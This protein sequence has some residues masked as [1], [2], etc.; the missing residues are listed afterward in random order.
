MAWIDYRRAFDVPRD[1]MGMSI[2]LAGVNDK[3]V[4]S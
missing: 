2:D 3:I 1:G 4:N